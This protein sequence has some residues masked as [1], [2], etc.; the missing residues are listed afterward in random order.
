MR[1]EESINHLEART[2]KDLKSYSPNVDLAPLE[3]W[4]SQPFALS[5]RDIVHILD[6]SVQ[7]MTLLPYVKAVRRIEQR[8]QPSLG[9]WW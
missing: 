8:P 6:E 1:V 4:K 5:G 2:G 9:G 3:V 7:M